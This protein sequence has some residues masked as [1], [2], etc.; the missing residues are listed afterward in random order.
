MI[1]RRIRALLLHDLS[2][3]SDFPRILIRLL[4]TLTADGARSKLWHA[5]LTMGSSIPRLSAVVLNSAGPRPRSLWLFLGAGCFLAVGCG[6]HAAETGQNGNAGASS[7]LCMFAASSYDQSCSA[8]TDCHEVTSTDY[9]ADNCLCG[10]S[11]INASAVPQFTHDTAK[12]PLAS[13]L[14][15]GVA[16]PCTPPSG[17]CC[18]GGKCTMTCESAS[19]AL[20]ACRDAGGTCVFGVDGTSCVKDGP[21]QSCAYSDEVCC[22]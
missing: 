5:V 3:G 16:C 6:E 18:R 10:G 19:D 11:A 15:G 20:P 2:G 7:G 4:K 13:G 8:D 21:P 1:R 22:L 12:T 17:P 9:C 14:L